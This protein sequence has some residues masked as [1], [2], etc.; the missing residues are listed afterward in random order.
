V[1][2]WLKANW[3]TVV[4]IVQRGAAH[5]GVQPDFFAYTIGLMTVKVR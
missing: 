4:S 3:A 1:P 5:L 2:A